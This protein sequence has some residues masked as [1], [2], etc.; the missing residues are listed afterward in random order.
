MLW[1]REAAI[2]PATRHHGNQFQGARSRKASAGAWDLGENFASREPATHRAH[3]KNLTPGGNHRL[4]ED[5]EVAQQPIW[6][7]YYVSPDR[8]NDCPAVRPASSRRFEIFARGRA[9]ARPRIGHL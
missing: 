4:G 6:R 8:G 3:K 7:T 1:R 5:D 9:P 2:F